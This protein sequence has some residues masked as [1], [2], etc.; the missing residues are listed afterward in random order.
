MNIVIYKI[1]IL[2]TGKSYIGI[3]NNLGRRI[4]QHKC[5]A[6]DKCTSRKCMYID[7]ING[8]INNYSIEVLDEFEFVS[9]EDSWE[10]ESQYI[11]KFNTEQC[12]YNVAYYGCKPKISKLKGIHL[13]P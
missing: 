9:Q 4:S 6:K 1:T 12:G 8:G 13:S 3:T 2:T 10:K 11:E 5:S 7:W